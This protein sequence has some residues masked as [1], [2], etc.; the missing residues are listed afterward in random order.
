MAMRILL[1]FAFV[2][3]VADVLPPPGVDAPAATLS[4]A[5]FQTMHIRV[6]GNDHG[7]PNI[8]WEIRHDATADQDVRVE[9]SGP[10]AVWLQEA[11]LLPSSV[12][13]ASD[14]AQ[15]ENAAV[16]HLNYGTS[17][18]TTAP[19]ENGVN[20][21]TTTMDEEVTSATTDEVASPSTTQSPSRDPAF[22]TSSTSWGRRVLLP[23]SLGATG[24][25]IG[26]PQ[27]HLIPA[28]ALVLLCV[29]AQ[30]SAQA[31]TTLANEGAYGGPLTL[32][33]VLQTD[34]WAGVGGCGFCPLEAMLS[35]RHFAWREPCPMSEAASE[36]NAMAAACNAQDICYGAACGL[37]GWCN[38]PA[39]P[40]QCTFSEEVGSR[41]IHESLRT[42][43]LGSVSG[44]AVTEQFVGDLLQCMQ[45]GMPVEGRPFIT[46]A[47]QVVAPARIVT[48]PGA[49]SCSS[50]SNP[51]AMRSFAP[52]EWTDAMSE[53]SSD[54]WLRHGQDEHAS[55][56]SF[57]RLSMDLLRFGAPPSLLLATHAAAADEV[58]HAQ[59]AFGLAARLGAGKAATVEVGSF[60]VEAVELSASLSKL[61][62]LAVDE[63][64][65]G[66]GAATARLEFALAALAPDSPARALVETLLDDEARHSALAWRTVRWAVTQG[67]DLGPRRAPG[68][69]AAPPARTDH[70]PNAMLTWAGRV[71]PAVAAEL[72]A[73]AEQSWVGPW[74]ESLRRGS[75]LPA[76]EV[77]PGSVGDAVSRSA[78]RVRALLDEEQQVTA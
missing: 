77:P 23:V 61:A 33:L 13:P 27:K 38:F 76:V 68:A 2:A 6:S 41:C 56:A 35:S 65:F 51:A 30:D 14:P 42:Q 62:G 19:P 63:G 53:S 69:P 26:L 57:S 54:A 72:A 40:G 12:G 31:Q 37:D 1:S 74:V 16:L 3:A 60:P 50:W 55:V 7:H 44:G 8:L 18:A 64:C 17:P 67:A 36:L 24:L 29:L 47:G 59:L 78:S 10:G 28:L 75:E 4:L 46:D 39:P 9:L 45:M 73:L 15:P 32:T 43:L 22:V 52:L 25:A 5:S 48:G 58:R 70:T 49:E 21:A 71:P 11:G 34:Q 66:E 20:S